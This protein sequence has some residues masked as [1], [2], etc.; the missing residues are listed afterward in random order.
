MCVLVCTCVFRL[1]L[2]RLQIDSQV[3][4][5][6]TYSTNQWAKMRGYFWESFEASSV[7][8]AGNLFCRQKPDKCPP[9]HA[10]LIRRQN[11]LTAGGC[12]THSWRFCKWVA[13]MDWFLGLIDRVDFLW[14]MTLYHWFFSL[15]AK[16]PL[17]MKALLPHWWNSW[18]YPVLKQFLIYNNSMAM[19]SQP[20]QRG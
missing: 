3:S 9:V 7:E 20:L 16:K 11:G 14:Q 18:Q 15:K 12:A 8:A 4:T 2:T 10:K 17:S 13:R 6:D 1:A 19:L 5:V